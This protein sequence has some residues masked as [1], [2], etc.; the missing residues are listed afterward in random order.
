MDRKFQKE[1]IPEDKEEDTSS[2][3]R[4]LHN[5]GNPIAP[6][7]EAHRLESNYHRDSLAGVRVLSPTS[8][9][10]AWGSGI[11]RKSPQS[12]WH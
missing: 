4:G 7:W 8:N 9:T 1:T 6:G 10:H 2:G 12:I 3:R 5:I 11:G